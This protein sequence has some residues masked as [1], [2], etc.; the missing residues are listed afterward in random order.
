MGLAEA[1]SGAIN[2][3]L[4]PSRGEA[5]NLLISSCYEGTTP[6]ADTTPVIPLITP[7]LGESAI[8][9]PCL[10]VPSPSVPKNVARDDVSKGITVSPSTRGLVSQKPEEQDERL[11]MRDSPRWEDEEIKKGGREEP[12]VIKAEVKL[13]VRTTESGK[14]TIEIRS[15]EEFVEVAEKHPGGFEDVVSTSPPEDESIV[16]NEERVFTLHRKSSPGRTPSPR[17]VRPVG[18][19]EG[20]YISEA[21]P[22]EFNLM[23]QIRGKPYL[24]CLSLSPFFR[25][26]ICAF[27][28]CSS[29]HLSVVRLSHNYLLT[30]KK[31]E[32]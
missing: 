10:R 32:E 28:S 29:N 24:A 21:T 19:E 1:K 2:Q 4:A 9:T 27:Y 25:R 20:S 7:L 11:M 26:L 3:R 13:L 6:H 30:L 31:T 12:P 8:D 23:S 5:S 16:Q 15:I 18:I 22:D 14:E 17:F